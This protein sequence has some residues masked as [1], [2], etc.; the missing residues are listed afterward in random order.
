MNL[1]K[2]YIIDLL[3]FFKVKKIYQT[4]HIRGIYPNI[5]Y[6]DNGGYQQRNYSTIN[7]INNV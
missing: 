1:I 7:L 2:K 3:Y 6:I 5:M 4:I